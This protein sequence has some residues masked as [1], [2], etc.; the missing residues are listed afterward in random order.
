MTNIGPLEIGEIKA[1][2]FDFSTEADSATTLNT[3]VVTCSLLSGTDATPS[4]VLYGSASVDAKEVVQLIHPGVA[5]CTYKLNAFVS[6][7]SGLRHHIA[8]KVSVVAG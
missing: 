4:A 6:D 5:G 1:L 3:P 2:R 8:A 7:S